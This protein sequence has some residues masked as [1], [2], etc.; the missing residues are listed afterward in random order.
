MRNR[1]EEDPE[2]EPEEAPP[3]AAATSTLVP[4]VA[5]GSREFEYRTELVTVAQVL[6]GST[7]AGQLG[8]A[9]VDGWDLVDILA[10]GDSHVVLLR[11]IKRSE[12]ESR[13]VGFT[14]PN[15]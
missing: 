9:S 8:K 10:A 4:A 12:R 1:F 5:D 3:A 6:D 11:R 15:H 13:T 2:E 7:L 14:P